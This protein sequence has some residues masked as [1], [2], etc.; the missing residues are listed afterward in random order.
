M[1]AFSNI[2]LHRLSAKTKLEMSVGKVQ[3]LMSSDANTIVRAGDFYISQHC[4]AL[5]CQ[6]PSVSRVAAAIDT[7]LWFESSSCCQQCFQSYVSRGE[8]FR[9]VVGAIKLDRLPRF[10]MQ[11]ASEKHESG[12]SQCT[13]YVTFVDV[14]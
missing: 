5:S 1:D 3:S 6:L 11:N 14:N 13:Q 8:G 4:A 10:I 12:Q 2:T 9:L 7:L